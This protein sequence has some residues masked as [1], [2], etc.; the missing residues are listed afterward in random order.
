MHF[1]W[2][3]RFLSYF[4]DVS[5][6]ELESQFS[7]KLLVSLCNERLKLTAGTAIYSEEDNYYNF[8]EVFKKIMI[9]E[10]QIQNVLVLGLGLG[11]IPQMLEKNFQRNYSFDAVEID[12]A[13]IH[14]FN[15]YIKSS[16]NSEINVLQQ[17]ATEFISINDKRYDLICVD[18]FINKDIPEQFIAKEFLENLHNSLEKGGFLIYNRLEPESDIE[19]TQKKFFESNF[20]EVFP[21]LKIYSIVR[22]EMYVSIKN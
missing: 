3:K 18:L 5:I 7:D 9:K 16:L 4:K 15:K 20:S 1:P 13:I 17:D 6:E 8:T 22:N 11:S 10:K 14:L 19:A 12:P 2:Y 21:N